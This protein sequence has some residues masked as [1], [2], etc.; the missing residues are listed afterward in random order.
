M[1]KTI[2]EMDTH[3]KHYSEVAEHNQDLAAAQSLEI[4]KLKRNH[5]E[6]LA[7]LNSRYAD[8][9]GNVRND[10][11]AKISSLKATLRARDEHIKELEELTYGV[12]E[13]YHAAERNSKVSATK[14]GEMRVTANN[15]LEKYKSLEQTLKELQDETEEERY[16]NDLVLLENECLKE[17]IEEIGNELIDAYHRIK[18]R[19]EVFG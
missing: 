17:R 12:S 14:E 15:R 19:H 5:E 8:S 18:V 6:E 7:K 2:R 4:S 16:N 1:N 9:L 3:V 11:S 13:E 10:H